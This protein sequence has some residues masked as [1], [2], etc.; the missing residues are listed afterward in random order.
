MHFLKFLT[1]NGFNTYN[2]FLLLCLFNTWGRILENQLLLIYI[3][4]AK[5]G[6]DAHQHQGHK[7]TFRPPQPQSKNQCLMHFS[8]KSWEPWNLVGIWVHF[9]AK[10]SKPATSQPSMHSCDAQSSLLTSQAHVPQ[11]F[12][13]TI[14]SFLIVYPSLSHQLVLSQANSSLY[15]SHSVFS[16]GLISRDSHHFIHS[17]DK[18]LI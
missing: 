8:V 4:R 16:R 14:D 10:L 3:T 1:I 12:F 13:H 2:S 11:N 6:I 17:F 18:P 9:R 5:S 15:Y 7:V